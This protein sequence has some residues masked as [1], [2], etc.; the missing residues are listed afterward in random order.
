MNK[1][2]I[3]STR[4]SLISYL[5][6]IAYSLRAP[7]WSCQLFRLFCGPGPPCSLNALSLSGFAGSD[8]AITHHLATP[9]LTHPLEKTNNFT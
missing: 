3:D 1:F 5:I 8:L 6:A 2:I 4:I 7:V 9:T